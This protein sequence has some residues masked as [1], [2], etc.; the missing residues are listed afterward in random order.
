MK[1]LSCFKDYYD[2]VPKIY[3]VDN[4]VV[5]VRD[6][7][8]HKV[9]A[10]NYKLV[11]EGG[12]ALPFYGQYHGYYGL[13]EQLNAI[14]GHLVFCGKRFLTIEENHKFRM[15][16]PEDVSFVKNSDVIERNFNPRVSDHLVALSKK[17]NSPVFYVRI[18]GVSGERYA[19]PLT[20]DQNIPIL[21]DIGFDKMYP[22]MQTYSEIYQFC[23]N[24]LRDNP[25]TIPPVYVKNENKILSA[26]FDLK[27]SFRNPIK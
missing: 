6:P 4:A 13:R 14:Y 5:Y 1:I 3:G 9:I 25:D 7:F 19:G 18:G 17:L 27:T 12:F 15:V 11:N 22:P 23:S 26:G 8:S 24:V 2:F 16:T 21:G 20:I 10:E